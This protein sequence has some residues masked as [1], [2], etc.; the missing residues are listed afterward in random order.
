MFKRLL[1]FIIGLVS[2][3]AALVAGFF[4]E[5]RYESLIA[6]TELP[7]PAIAIPVNAVISKTML[8]MKAFPSPMANEAVYHRV[9]E[10]VGKVATTPLVPGELIYR[11]QVVPPAQYVFTDDE[12]LE[13]VSFPVSPDSA[14]GG[15]IKIGQ[16]INIYR[17]ALG[18]FQPF[19]TTVG[20]APRPSNNEPTP[21]EM[22]KGS[23]VGV[24]V[25]AGN[26][27]VV[28]VRASGGSPVQP[29]KAQT[30]NG[31]SPVQQSAPTTSE[32]RPLTILTVAVPPAVA[33]DLIRLQGETH[34]KYL[35][36][37]TLT[38]LSEATQ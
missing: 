37:I 3:G 34:D 25:L 16:H 29:I 7:V 5:S 24:Q 35:L 4:A 33:A 14:V 17:V 12:R 2:L 32:A 13:V 22:L 11:Q 28:D 15:Q 1:P 19:T 20:A 38:P 23:P 8:V 30:A 6:T 10:V 36:W 27:T 9:E 26:V 21:S 18:A 31:T